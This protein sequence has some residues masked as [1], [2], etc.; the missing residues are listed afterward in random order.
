MLTQCPRQVYLSGARLKRLHWAALYH[1]AAPS[2]PAVASAPP[3]DNALDVASESTRLSEPEED[4]LSGAEADGLARFEY[5]DLPQW[6]DDL[7]PTWLVRR[8]A[9]RTLRRRPVLAEALEHGGVTGGRSLPALPDEVWELILTLLPIRPDE[10]HVETFG[11]LGT[12]W[13][14]NPPAMSCQ[15]WIDPCSVIPCSGNRVIVVD[16]GHNRLTM[17]IAASNHPRLLSL[18]GDTEYGHK[19]GAPASARFAFPRGAALDH[20][21]TIWVTDRNCVRRLARG[22]LEVSCTPF[23]FDKSP[24]PE[25]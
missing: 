20:H 22:T 5:G 15:L 10:Y 19:D 3:S 21:G 23:M 11:L 17:L 13:S 6:V 7:L 9:P 24:T 4:D 25:A 18:A 2:T 14:A 12:G 16:S 1:E 8:F